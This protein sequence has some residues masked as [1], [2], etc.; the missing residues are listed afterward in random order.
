[1]KANGTTFQVDTL[2]IT[3]QLLYLLDIK[4]YEGDY[5]YDSGKFLSSVMQEI[6]SP[7]TQLERSENLLRLL[8]QNLGFTIPIAPYVVFIN[9]EFTL[10]NAP[11]N[12][13]LIFPTQ[14]NRF[15][16]QIELNSNKLTVKHKLLAE[17]LVSSQI[18]N[19]F[20][21]QNIPHYEYEKLKKGISC[22]ECTSFSIDRDKQSIICK[23]CGHKE[24][25]KNAVLR[26]IE[27]YKILFPEKLI[28][29]VNIYDW[30]GNIVSKKQIRT[31][32]GSYYKLVGFG[33]WSYYE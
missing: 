17:K 24:L 7:L 2:I 30:C 6:K 27:E 10:Y 31:I 23:D 25:I 8:I 3:S 9:P 26:S 18:R 13:R 15:I 32:L 33:R 21:E 29:T 28:S 4:N 11:Q 1:M 12:E 20:S 22:S 16:R 14:I 5:N 19:N